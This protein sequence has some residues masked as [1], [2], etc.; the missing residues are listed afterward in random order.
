MQLRVMLFAHQGKG[1]TLQETPANTSSAQKL[2]RN[3]IAEVHFVTENGCPVKVSFITL[4]GTQDTLKCQ[5]PNVLF[6]S[7]LKNT[8]CG[9]EL[10]R[11]KPRCG[12]A[13]EIWPQSL[14][15]PR[16]RHHISGRRY[17]AS[18]KTPKNVTLCQS[19]HEESYMR[20]SKPLKQSQGRC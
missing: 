11:R 15:P 7:M 18:F 16:K 14:P 1:R 10:Y 4:S 6:E 13:A 5:H 19:H 12:T 17:P 20:R 9:K 2:A 3:E 8:S